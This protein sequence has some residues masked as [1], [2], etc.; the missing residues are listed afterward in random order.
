MYVFIYISL[1]IMED[2]RLLQLIVP[3]CI[4]ISDLEASTKADENDMVSVCTAL[5]NSVWRPLLEAL[6]FILTR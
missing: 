6:S 3:S 4:P 2:F 1:C 5:A